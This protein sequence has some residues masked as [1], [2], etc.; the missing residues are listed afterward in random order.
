MRRFQRVGRAWAEPPYTAQRA[1]RAW[2]TGAVLLATLR[3]L[4]SRS[5][6]AFLLR[7]FRALTPEL[8][9]IPRGPLFAL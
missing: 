2:D 6:S 8:Q 3:E 1:G 4:P 9:H 5:F 7:P